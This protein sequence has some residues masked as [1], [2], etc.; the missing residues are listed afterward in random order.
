[1]KKYLSAVVFFTLSQMSFA[2]TDLLSLSTHTEGATP[3]YGE[4]VTIGMVEN[5]GVKYV[6]ATP[7]NSGKLKFPVSLSGNFEVEFKVLNS[8]SISGQIDF[9]LTA[10]E[11]KI[12]VHFARYGSIKLT[13]DSQSGDGDASGAFIEY[14]SNAFRISISN[15]IAKLYV[16]D[17][18]SQKVTL[19]PD[20]T[21]T[22]ILMGGIE[23]ADSVFALSISG[24]ASVADTG[25]T[26]ACTG[27]TT[28][29]SSDFGDCMANYLNGKLHVPCVAVSDPFGGTTVYDIKMQQQSS[30]FTFD[31]DMNSVKPR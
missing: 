3:S 11:H 10:D 19:T 4:N 12:F 1:M 14:Q 22:Q 27:N 21:Y 6:T 31:L 16:N 26:G 5:T 7:D 13:A 28:P 9:F 29:T 30:G 20:L 24:S 8:G 17:V 25:N 2:N 18:F 23:P 15:N